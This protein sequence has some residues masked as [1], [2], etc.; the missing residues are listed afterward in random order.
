[1]SFQQYGRNIVRES[2]DSHAPILGR[3][4]EEIHVLAT[5]LATYVSSESTTAR[6]TNR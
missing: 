1:M 3:T 5:S 2:W 4:L 6:V